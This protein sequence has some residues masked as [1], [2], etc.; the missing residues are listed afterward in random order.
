MLENA[1]LSIN[2]QVTLLNKCCSEQ[3]LAIEREIDTLKV[4]VLSAKYTITLAGN[5][6]QTAHCHLIWQSSTTVNAG[7]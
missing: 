2:I 7:K 6:M 3:L 5:Q 1:S 4:T